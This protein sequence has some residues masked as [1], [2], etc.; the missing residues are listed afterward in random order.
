MVGVSRGVFPKKCGE[1][2]SG[3]LVGGLIISGGHDALGWDCFDTRLKV[4]DDG[5]RADVMGWEVGS[6]GS[7]REL[8]IDLGTHC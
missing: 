8:I 3:T 1:I 7:E 5:G 2:E 4:G 6:A